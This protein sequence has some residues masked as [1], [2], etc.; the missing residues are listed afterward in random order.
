M[1]HDQA[2]SD[3]PYDFEN[4]SFGYT[5]VNTITNDNEAYAMLRIAPYT[6]KIKNLCLK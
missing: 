3:L 5:N 2:V 4:T 6:E 1:S